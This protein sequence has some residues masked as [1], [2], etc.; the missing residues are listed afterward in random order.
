M[1]SKKVKCKNTRTT[2]RFGERKKAKYLSGLQLLT[3]PKADGES[4]VE[5]RQN[6]EERLPEDSIKR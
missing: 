3:V 6:T 2:A 5:K 4:K 1:N